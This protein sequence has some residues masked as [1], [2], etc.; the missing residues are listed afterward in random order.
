MV[1]FRWSPEKAAANLRKHGVGFSEAKTAFGDPFSVAV[2][3]PGHSIGEERWI[4]VG[5]SENDRLLAV[6]DVDRRDEIRVVSARKATRS[7][8]QKYEE[9]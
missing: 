5:R 4:L 3:D 9:I 7:E 2:P 8:R 1:R 6:A